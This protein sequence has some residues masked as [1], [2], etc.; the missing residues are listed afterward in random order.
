MITLGGPQRGGTSTS[1]SYE[2][3][4]NGDNAVFNPATLLIIY[5]YMYIYIYV[6]RSIIRSSL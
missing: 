2:D 5:V 3:L 4:D 6:Y 1:G